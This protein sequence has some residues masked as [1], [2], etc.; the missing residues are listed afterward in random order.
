MQARPTFHQVFADSS[1]SAAA[2]MAIRS[3]GSS[4]GT[5]SSRSST[6]GTS[7]SEERAP[8]VLT[9]LFGRSVSFTMQEL[10][11]S[12]D[13]YMEEVSMSTSSSTTTTANGT[14]SNGNVIATGPS[15]ASS[16]AAPQHYGRPSRTVVHGAD[17][18]SVLEKLAVLRHLEK[19]V[20]AI[21]DYL[22]HHRAAA[23]APY[24]PQPQQHPRLVDEFCREQICEWCYRVVDY[25]DISREVVAIALSFLDRFLAAC[26]CDR[27]TYKLAATT[28]LFLAVKVHDEAHK[29][30]NF[31]SVLANL[32]RGEFEERHVTEMERLMLRALGFRVHP[33]TTVAF[34]NHIMLLPPFSIAEPQEEDHHSSTT[35]TSDPLQMRLPR[36]LSRQI[37]DTACFYSELAVLDY[38]FVTTSPS[39]LAFASIMEAMHRHDIPPKAYKLFSD[40]VPRFLTQG[41]TSTIPADQLLPVQTN[42]RRCYER[43]YG[44]HDNNSHLGPPATAMD[45][46]SSSIHTNQH[47]QATSPVSVIP[48]NTNRSSSLY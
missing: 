4:S 43:A 17:P 2:G 37:F 22:A 28:A 18:A 1:A 6:T 46:S 16:G 27:R 40:I 5:S 47:L 41:T 48:P 32:S 36:G 13:A 39:L 12:R 21:P 45:L 29:R 25:F 11:E 15:S 30:I 44:S 33:P 8:V 35:T 20:Y 3:S 42:L 14:R 26:S 9:A 31:L 10:E 7:S 23:A 38:S 34:I 19:E 24:P